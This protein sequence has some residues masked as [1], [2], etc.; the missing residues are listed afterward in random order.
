MN[1]A[2]DFSELSKQE[3]AKYSAAYSSAQTGEK[4]PRVLASNKDG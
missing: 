3:Q 2:I 1:A 4:P